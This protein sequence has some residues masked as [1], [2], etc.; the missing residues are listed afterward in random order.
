MQN[1]GLYHYYRRRNRVIFEQIFTGKSHDAEIKKLNVWSG[2]LEIDGAQ[3]GG[4]YIH[5]IGIP[6]EGDPFY[7]PETAGQPMSLTGH[8]STITNRLLAFAAAY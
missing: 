4:A 5:N 8:D 1:V 7:N 2:N 6:K 3:L